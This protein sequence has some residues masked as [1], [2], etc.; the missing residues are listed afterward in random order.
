MNKKIFLFGNG[1]LSWEN[2][3]RFYIEPLK[4]TAV[5]ECEFII[6]NFAGTDTMM[7]EYLKDK[8]ENVTIIH[9]KDRPRYSVNTFRNKASKWKTVGGFVSDAER[10]NFGISNCTHF[11]AVD[12]NSDETRKSGTL[13]NIEKCVSL[14]RIKL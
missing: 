14:G 11:L 3:H 5:S 4:G 13:K 9:M 7:M 8:T 2:F 10:D 6:G 12:F 1:N